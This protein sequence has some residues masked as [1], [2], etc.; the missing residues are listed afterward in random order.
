MV[1]AKD[2]DGPGAMVDTGLGAGL[3]C[4][5]AEANTPGTTSKSKQ[6]RAYQAEHFFMI[7]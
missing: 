1:G 5:S 4:V 3:W 7:T 2:G 6:N